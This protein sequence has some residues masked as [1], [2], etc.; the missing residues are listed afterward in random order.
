M[1]RLC[2]IFAF[3]IVLTGCATQP[4]SRHRT[5]NRQLPDGTVVDY[6]GMPCGNQNMRVKSPLCL[7]PRTLHASGM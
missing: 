7:Y 1:K 3:A 5:S 4:Q 2:T 6:A